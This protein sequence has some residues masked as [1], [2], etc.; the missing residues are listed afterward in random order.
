M[1]RVLLVDTGP[2]VALLDRSDAHHDW[3]VAV[4]SE[5]R[6]PLLTC[7]AVAA[8]ALFLCRRNRVDPRALHTLLAERE[9]RVASPLNDAPAAIVQLLSRYATVPTSLADA[10][11]L[12]LHETTPRSVV[13]TCDSDFRVYRR[14]RNRPVDALMPD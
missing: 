2:L 12:W 11:V 5:L 7:E 3:A 9:L 8:E 14:S 10:C 4:F 6:A 13:L 1:S